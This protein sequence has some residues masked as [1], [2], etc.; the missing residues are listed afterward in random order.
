MS[1]SGANAQNRAANSSVSMD[2]LSVTSQ[3]HHHHNNASSQERRGSHKFDED[4]GED[5]RQNKLSASNRSL[6][7]IFAVS[8]PSA[9]PTPKSATRFNKVKF[10]TPY[11]DD[12]DD[13]DDEVGKA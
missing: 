5:D 9:G 7:S 1:A 10:T 12:D 2:L 4:E 3:P 6:A 8:P 13:D 11:D